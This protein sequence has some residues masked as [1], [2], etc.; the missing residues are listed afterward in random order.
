[1]GNGC[2]NRRLT[3][4][5]ERKEKTIVHASWK[6]YPWCGVDWPSPAFPP[7]SLSCQRNRAQVGEGPSGPT[8]WSP[9]IGLISFWFA[10]NAQ[11]HFTVLDS[12][13]RNFIATYRAWRRRKTAH[14]YVMLLPCTFSTIVI[15]LDVS[16][17]QPTS[18]NFL[19][20]NFVFLFFPDF[21]SWTSRQEMDP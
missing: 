10:S 4:G 1:V 2:D 5:Q 21:E 9:C 14:R 7:R 13:I 15:R 16:S 8:P 18:N 19:Q 17:S 11:N 6:D 3:D 20:P 12:A